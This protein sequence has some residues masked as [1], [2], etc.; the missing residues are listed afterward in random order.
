MKQAVILGSLLLLSAI[1]FCQIPN[2]TRQKAVDSLFVLLPKAIGKDSVDV[3]NQLS[4]QIAPRNFDS[5]FRYANQALRLS[6]KLNYQFGKGIAT[7]NIGNS[8]YFKPDLKNALKNYH[9]ALRILEPFEPSVQTGNLLEQLAA[10]NQYVRNTEKSTSYYKR[11][12]SNY[13][14]IGDSNNAISTYLKLSNS[15]YFK[16]QTMGSLGTLSSE[17][18]TIMVDSAQKFL[19][20]AFEYYARH[21]DITI[22][23]GLYNCQGVYYQETKNPLALDNFYKA[24][25]A[26]DRL[27]DS[28]ERIHWKGQ[29]LMNIGF[30]Y[31]FFKGDL[32]KGYSYSFRAKT[33][34]NTVENYDNL[35]AT[36]LTLGEIDTDRGHYQR[37][38]KY[39]RD[40]IC[41]LDTFMLNIIHLENHSAAH[42][43]WGITQARAWRISGLADLVRVYELSGDYKKALDYQKKLTS[44]KSLQSLDELNRAIV[45]LE[46]QYEDDLKRQEIGKLVRDNEIHRLKLNRTRLLFAGIGG[47]LVIVFL[48]TILYIQRKRF[49][50]DRKALALEQKLLRARMNPHFIFNSLYS[51][52]N[53]I[54]TEKP[55]KASIYLSKFARLVRNILDYSI[56]EFVSLEKEIST[57][58]NYIELQQVRY[59]GKFEY[60]IEIDDAIDTETTMIP[61]ML[62]Q[63]F[64]ENAIEHG[65]KHRITPGHIGI[66]FS[67]KDHTLFFEVLDDG[68]GRQKAFELETMQEQGHRSM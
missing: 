18:A 62:A 19:R 52:Q 55:D 65:I 24:L 25:K 63:P 6:G 57:I 10:V 51:I 47:L 68:V 8:Y 37:A 1:L 39:L 5:G 21:P 53:F 46:A 4:L 34:L 56:E 45:G 7:F 49:R 13:I 40:A 20:K 58:E 28:N 64:I 16:F 48:T 17:N 32:V 42:R 43:I 50:S 41:L 3:L 30:Y 29:V 59:A 22:L 44:E 33:L 26:C 12:I 36:L 66:R 11:A 14:T 23:P 54:V 61:P 67:L 27:S 2:M 60:R 15:Y 38:E 35:A 31:Y 9:T